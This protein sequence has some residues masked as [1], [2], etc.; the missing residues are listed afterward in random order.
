M[1][2]WNII[3]LNQSIINRNTKRQSDSFSINF[4]FVLIHNQYQKKRL[5]TQHEKKEAFITLQQGHY[6]DNYRSLNFNFRITRLHMAFQM[7][8]DY[9]HF[10]GSFP[11]FQSNENDAKGR[12]FP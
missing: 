11:W 2:P 7:K 12:D 4:G 5:L 1:T 9:N 10:V 3:K 6:T 8:G